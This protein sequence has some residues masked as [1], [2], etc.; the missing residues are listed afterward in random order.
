MMPSA[1]SFVAVM[2]NAY[3]LLAI[4]TPSNNFLNVNPEQIWVFPEV[5]LDVG[6]ELSF[7]LE[8]HSFHNDPASQVV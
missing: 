7:L 4:D 3:C 1:W 2:Q 8:R 5:M 6:K